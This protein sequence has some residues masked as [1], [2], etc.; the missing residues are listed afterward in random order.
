M[1]GGYGISNPETNNHGRAYALSAGDGSGP[2]WPMFRH[3]CLHSACFPIAVNQ[4]PTMGNISGPLYGR[5]G[6]NYTFCITVTD[7]EADTVFCLWDWGDGTYSG[8]LGPYAS[9]EEICVTHAWSDEGSFSIRV[10]LKDE[11]GAE[12]EW[13]EA[14]KIIIDGTPPVLEIIKPKKGFLYLWD[15]PVLPL[16]ITTLVIGSITVEVSA[17]DNGSGM[18]HV[19]FYLDDVL[20][21]T[22]N[23]SENN[24]YSW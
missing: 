14:F 20:K 21:A 24:T 6:V 23:T 17:V 2:G 7:P 4:P 12:S 16:F 10:K 19:E 8:W 1:I 13:S 9:G 11:Y 22:D 15:K 5:P 18:S 3:D